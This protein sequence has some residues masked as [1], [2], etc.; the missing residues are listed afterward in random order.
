MPKPS[1]T[2]D[3]T[4]LTGLNIRFVSILHADLSV[5]RTRF[6]PACPG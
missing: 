3:F 4:E 5:A 1:E 2:T 6:N